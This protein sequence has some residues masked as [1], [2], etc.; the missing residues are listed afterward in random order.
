MTNWRRR[1][2]VAGTPMN[3]DFQF[4]GKTERTAYD[5]YSVG[6]ERSRSSASS[7]PNLDGNESKKSKRVGWKWGPAHSERA[8]AQT[9]CYGSPKNSSRGHMSAGRIQAGQCSAGKS[10]NETR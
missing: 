7:A 8:A 2:R 4:N 5:H 10:G 1:R 6:D 3:L 9:E